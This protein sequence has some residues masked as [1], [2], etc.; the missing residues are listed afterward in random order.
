MPLFSIITVSKNN[1]TGLQRTATSIQEQ[2]FTDFQWIIVDAVSADG[3]A[4]DLPDY[5]A[6]LL[7]EPDSGPYDAMNKGIDLAIG[8]YIIFMNSGDGFA[9]TQTL[10]KIRDAIWFSKPDFIYGDAWE[11]DGRRTSYKPARSYLKADK[12]MFTHHQAMFYKRSLIRNLRYDLSYKIA[13]DYDFTLAF[14]NAAQTCLYLPLPVCVFRSGGLSQRNVI[15]G[16]NEQFAIRQKHHMTS[17]PRN[18]LTYAIQTVTWGLRA[19]APGLYW[20]LKKS[21]Q[22]ERSDED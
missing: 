15:L 13:A 8:D 19:C 21:S 17:F 4:D 20:R 1:R 2:E 7:C 11:T 18:A 10:Q 22:R 12:G 3:T 16:R 5:N 14:L 9:Q 6:T